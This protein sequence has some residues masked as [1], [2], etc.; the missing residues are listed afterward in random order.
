[1]D[2]PAPRAAA[3]IPAYK[4]PGLLGE[5]ILSVL[6]QSAPA[7]AVVV[8]DGCPM[9]ETREVAFSF[10][11]AHPGRV[12]VLR[13]H[14]GGLS[15]ARNTGIAFALKCWPQLEALMFLDAD[16][17]IEKDYLARALEA[18]AAAPAEVGWFY[19]DIDMIGLDESSSMRGAFSR[20]ALLDWNY[21]DAGSVV[22]RSLLDSGLRFDE[23]LRD[24]FEDWDFWL[25]A[26]EAGFRGQYLANAGFL[27]RK[28]GESML[29]SSARRR[30]TIVAA[31]NR[32]RR[33]ALRPRNLL[34]LEAK[35]APRFAIVTETGDFARFTSDPTALGKEV[36]LNRAAAALR[37]AQARPGAY[38]APPVF[39]FASASSLATLEQALVMADVFWLAQVLLRDK[40][41]VAVFLARGKGS[42]LSVRRDKRPADAELAIVF[43]PSQLVLEAAQSDI[44][45][46]SWQDSDRS[47]Q[48]TVTIPEPFEFPCST[49]ALAAMKSF[50]TRLR[51]KP[52]APRD[53]WRPDVRP[54]RSNLIGLYERLCDVGVPLPLLPDSN[55]RGDIG[56]LVPIHSFGGV[57]KVVG[58]QARVLRALGYRTHLFISSGDG[59]LLTPE[60]QGS[61]C[62][63]N[64]LLSP[65]FDW[66]APGYDY[67]GAQMSG[68]A[69]DGDDTQRRDALGLLCGMDVVIE[70]HSLGGRCI[71][72]RLRE[73]GVRT[74]TTLH[75]VDHDS[76]GAPVGNPHMALAYEHAYDRIL[77]ISRNLRDWCLAHGI[78]R[79]KILLLPNA[80]AYPQSDGAESAREKR[81]ARIPG[82]LRVLFLGRLDPQ[83]GLDR[84]AAI[85]ATT[86]G[87]KFDW[88]VVGKAVVS[89]ATKGV[90][91]GVDIEPPVHDPDELDALYDW[92]DALVMPSR[93]EG[94]PLTILE[95]RRRGVVVIATDVGAVSEVI[96]EG[97]YLI[98]AKRDDAAIV[99]NIV[100]NLKALAHDPAL[101]AARTEA[102]LSEPPPK[103]EEM[104]APLI[105]DLE[106]MASENVTGRAQA[107]AAE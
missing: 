5:A 20:L 13:R 90:H 57:E 35:E 55:S 68:F 3:I 37:V 14:N 28:R 16:N 93:Y 39:C 45:E 77:V 15:A 103:W 19:P 96:G 11:R 48:I 95:A 101:L 38:H 99:V 59:F 52:Q 60:T 61:F 53:D 80:P 49:G 41:V 40:G 33:D 34:A 29:T 58:N 89:E 36:P 31:M 74:M 56:F 98:D 102:V 107:P 47:A 75:L 51:K 50:I 66:R 91:L 4:Q 69:R 8:D 79:E 32:K 72:A 7:A 73:W 97:G 64:L 104:L 27:Y 1:M 88:R 92:A 71:M 24:G 23:S 106:S 84:L 70:T 30:E 94:A 42:E 85:I 87:K 17:R 82:P 12:F 62:S 6:R 105:A 26:A 86:R 76:I 21:C 63:V 43:A 100:A 10:S 65:D 78:P 2:V 18:M 46:L 44:T 22:R 54:A 83:K 81:A 67:F 25:Q 9:E